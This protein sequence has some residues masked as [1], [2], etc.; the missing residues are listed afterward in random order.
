LFA[1]YAMNKHW[2]FKL[3]LDNITD[4]LTP[5][6]INSATL[7]E[8]NMGRCFTFHANYSF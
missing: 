2:S 1:D 8:T 3:V 7:I 4:G 6:A 5:L